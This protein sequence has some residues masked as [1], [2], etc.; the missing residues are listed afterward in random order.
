MAFSITVTAYD[1]YGNLA[2][3]YVGTVHFSSSDGR[4]ALPANYTFTSGPGGDNGVHVFTG[5]VLKK[6]GTQTITLTDTL[7]PSVT[8]ALSLDV[9]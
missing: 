7:V 6:R 8:G 5:L 1:V 4:A 9:F 3:G 2:T